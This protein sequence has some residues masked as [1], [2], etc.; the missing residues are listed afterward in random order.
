MRLNST[1][2]Y[3]YRIDILRGLWSLGVDVVFW[4]GGGDGTGRVRAGDRALGSKKAGWHGTMTGKTAG[5][6]R[7]Y[8]VHRQ[9]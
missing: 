8:N 4:G 5:A 2:R 3:T 9:V 1:S 7:T 6:P